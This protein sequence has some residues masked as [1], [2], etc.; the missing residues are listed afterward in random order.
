MYNTYMQ[1]LHSTKSIALFVE[2]DEAGSPSIVWHISMDLSVSHVYL[3]FIVPN[4]ALRACLYT[5]PSQM[6]YEFQ[7]LAL[8]VHYL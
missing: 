8:Y 6:N 7:S 2:V 4:D 3:S 5:I 1:Q